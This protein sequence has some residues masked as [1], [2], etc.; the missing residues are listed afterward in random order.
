M[1]AAL[2]LLALS[3]PASA[4]EELN[5]TAGYAAGKEAAADAPLGMPTAVGLTGG[6]LCAGAG[7]AALGILGAPAV[8]VGAAGPP[9]VM[10]LRP[11]APPEGEWSEGPRP[12]QLGYVDGYGRITRK[13]QA[14]V[15]AVAGVLG[16]G[17]GAGAG[18][19]T[20]L[21]VGSRLGYG[22]F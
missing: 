7:C 13:R 12:Y 5:Y 8:L 4:E 9:L 16:A 11:L 14:Q 21:V 18:V 22:P 15:A 2:L 10:Y 6:F 17:L 19:V 3:S 20:V 1:N